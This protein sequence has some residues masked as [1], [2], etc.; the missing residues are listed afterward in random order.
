[1]L[2]RR[3]VSELACA[4]EEDCLS[5]IT[6]RIVALGWG[7]YFYR[8]LLRFDSFIMNLGRR[9]FLPYLDR[10]EWEWHECH[11]HYH[12]HSHFVTYEL[13]Y[14]SDLS[15]NASSRERYDFLFS[16]GRSAVEGHKA[17]FCLQD[18]MCVLEGSSPFFQ[19][20]S[21]DAF[22][23]I[24]VGCGDLYG[25][26]LDCSW[27][28]VTN[29]KKNIDYFFR[30]TVNP[31]RSSLESDYLNN[32]VICHITLYSGTVTVHYCESESRGVCFVHCTFGF[33]ACVQ[34]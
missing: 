32:V 9:D 18:S 30:L 17:S 19:C 31:Q 26:E 22:Q 8:T 34:I 27:I 6:K 13:I 14:A 20:S 16:G 23:G 12:S 25:S 24:S 4:V 15:K 5:S 1:M 29:A 3:K 28:D 21:V 33:D 2:D 7:D 11:Q 10:S